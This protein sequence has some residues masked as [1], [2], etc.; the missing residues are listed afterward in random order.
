MKPIR[1]I[2]RVFPFIIGKP[3]PY[4]VGPKVEEV[5]NLTNVTYARF[6]GVIFSTMKSANGLYRYLYTKPESPPWYL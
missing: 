1:V 6:S 5:S 3:L 2:Y 4:H